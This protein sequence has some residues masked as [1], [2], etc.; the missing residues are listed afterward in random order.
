M[1]VAGDGLDRVSRADVECDPSIY[2]SKFVDNMRQLLFAASQALAAVD[3]IAL[4]RYLRSRAP[5]CLVPL[6]QGIHILVAPL[7]ARTTKSA[8]ACLCSPLL[9]APYLRGTI[10]W[11]WRCVSLSPA[12]A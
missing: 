3:L 9:L 12:V 2:V 5:S 7:D 10:A 4:R 8:G 1:C 6:A 11:G